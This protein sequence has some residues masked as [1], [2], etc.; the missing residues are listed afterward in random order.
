MKIH[1]SCHSTHQR[2]EVASTCCDTHCHVAMRTAWV[3]DSTDILLV[4]T[5]LKINMW[6]YCTVVIDSNIDT[7]SIVISSPPII[8]IY[9]IGTVQ[10]TTV[11]RF[12]CTW[13]RNQFYISY[14]SSVR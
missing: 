10:M 6:S 2:V 11:V 13:F 3:A 9:G 4:Q 12:W 1:T 5:S 14:K 7:C 8:A